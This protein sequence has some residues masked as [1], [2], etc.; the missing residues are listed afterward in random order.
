[1]DISAD[2]DAVT[3]RVGSLV[4]DLG[5]RILDSHECDKDRVALA[6]DTGQGVFAGGGESLRE[7]CIAAP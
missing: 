7:G 3:D 5:A 1:M 4:A 6:A 2:D